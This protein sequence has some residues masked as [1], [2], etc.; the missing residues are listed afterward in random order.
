MEQPLF[1]LPA[2]PLG[3]ATAGEFIFA[4]DASGAWDTHY[5]FNP[6][7]TLTDS[8]DWNYYSRVWEWD[9]VKRRMYFFRDDTS[10]NDLHYETI[11]AAGKITGEGETPYH[12]DF[13]VTPPIRVSPDGSRVVIGSGVVFETTGLTRLVTLPNTFTDA[14]WRTGELLTIRASGTTQTQLQRWDA[15][16]FAAG[17][18]VPLFAG[19]PLRLLALDSERCVLITLDRGMPRFRL[20]NA[21][22]SVSYD[23]L[24]DAPRITGTPPPVSEDMPFTW[25]PA[26]WKFPTAGTVTLT[27]PVLPAWLAFSNGTLAGTPREADSGDQINRS[28]NHRVVLRA[29]DNLGLS[30]EREFMVT[31]IWQNDAP[32]FKANPA[33]ILANDRAD[34]SQ[35]DLGALM[36]DPDLNDT[37][38]WEIIANTNPVIFSNIRVDHAG[39]LEIAYAPYRSGTSMVTV[40]VTDASGASAS[41]TLQVVLPELP[42]PVV[43]PDPMIRLSRLTGLYE[44]SIT[45]TNV[46][47]RAIAG[48]ELSLSGL[49]A[50]VR[51]YNGTS[52]EN[53][54]GL[55]AH[56][57]PL[58][59]GESITLIL[60]YYA[61]PRGQFPPPVF[62]TSV[63]VPDTST[64]QAAN[65]AAAFAVNRL[66]KQ[67]DGSVVIEFT[68]EP[69]SSYRVQYSADAALWKS[70]PVPIKAGGTKVQW[71]DR[72]PPWTESSPASQPRRFY[73]VERFDP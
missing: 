40:Q 8:T 11:D 28:K 70:C 60:E 52:S 47:A 26:V 56:H 30:E 68:A 62:A 64:H 44:Q 53:G 59:A 23:Y 2:T 73:R 39:L 7:G 66:V 25:T 49:R 33:P 55:I 37:H 58:Q 1:A 5:L 45:V 69:G 54:G 29:V 9:P 46:A 42:V 13:T 50:G 16:S 72:G 15:A 21:D 31:S 38:L 57:Q 65:G 12:G 41:T 35:L 22:L 67:A 18:G 10:P 17:A 36:L 24:P 32:T 63:T 48:F 51:L 4:S 20:L 19:T 61:S 43:T 27:A 6:A 71:I 3:L 14:L 34:D